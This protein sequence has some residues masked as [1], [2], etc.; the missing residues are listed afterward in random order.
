[1]K[2]RIAVIAVFC[3]GLLSASVVAQ[4]TTR[5]KRTTTKTDRF[6]FGVGGTL[7]V[8]GAPIGSISVEG[9]SSREVEITAEIQVEADSEADL[10]ALSEVIGFLLDESLGRVSI[11]SIGTNDRK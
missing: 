3:L 10:A 7:A 5:L 1:M 8:T 6:D 11:T 4:T 2:I 9:W